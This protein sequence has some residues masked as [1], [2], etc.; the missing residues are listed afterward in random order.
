[1]SFKRRENNSRLFANS[2][3]SILNLAILFYYA[4]SPESSA[5][6]EV[7]F[8]LPLA[9]LLPLLICLIYNAGFIIRNMRDAYERYRDQAT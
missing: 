5:V 2:A 8:Y 6:S 1:M 3:I 4:F 7:A 9:I